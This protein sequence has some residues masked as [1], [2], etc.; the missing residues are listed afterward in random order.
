MASEPLLKRTGSIMVMSSGLND[1]LTATPTGMSS[2][3]KRRF[4]SKSME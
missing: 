4:V 3:S 2:E 1:A